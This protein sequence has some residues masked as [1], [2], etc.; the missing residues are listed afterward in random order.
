MEV[1]FAPKA[2]QDIKSWKASGNAKI[3]KKIADLINAVTE[4]PFAGIGKPEPLKHEFSG[5]WSRRIN[6]EHRMIYE[7]SDNLIKVLSLKDHYK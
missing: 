3:Q 2:L 6:E 4:R 5:C 7:V 1:E